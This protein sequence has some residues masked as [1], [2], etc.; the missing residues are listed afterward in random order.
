[1]NLVEWPLWF[2]LTI[3]DGTLIKSKCEVL[4][5]CNTHVS[6][7]FLALGLFETVVFV[8]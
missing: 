6:T 3:C 5:H 8:V 4:L 7:A 1:M 2:D